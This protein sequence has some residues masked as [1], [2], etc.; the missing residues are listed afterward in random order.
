MNEQTPPNVYSEEFKW[1]VVKEVV[2]GR[3]TKEEAQR[4]YGIRSKTAVLYWMRQ[5]SGVADYRKG[6]IPLGFI[7]PMEAS[8]ELLSLQ[9]RITELEQDRDR[10]RLR[11]DLWQKMVELAEANLKIDIKKKFGARQSKPFAGKE[12]EG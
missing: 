2:E 7:E 12:T 11:A 8:K 10:E 5:F 1:R 3:Y 9:Q 4:V 6:G